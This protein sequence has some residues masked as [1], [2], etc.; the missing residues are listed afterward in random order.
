MFDG[1]IGFFETATQGLTPANCRSYLDD[2][3]QDMD[4]V[5]I[6]QVQRKV[7]SPHQYINNPQ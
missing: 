7:R 3:P 1:V 6:D 4:V 2:L 5:R